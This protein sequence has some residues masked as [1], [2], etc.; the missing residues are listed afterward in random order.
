MSERKNISSH[1]HSSNRDGRTGTKPLCRFFLSGN[2]KFGKKCHFKHEKPIE[3]SPLKEKLDEQFFLLEIR[4]TNSSTRPTYP[5]S[6]P[7]VCFS[8]LN[9]E[10]PPSYSLKIIARLMQEAKIMANQEA[11]SVFALVS[12]LENED[13]IHTAIQ[14]PEISFSFAP[15]LVPGHVKKIEYAN[16]IDSKLKSLNVDEMNTA[17]DDIGQHS[18]KSQAERKF[19]N[20]NILAEN[21]ILRERLKS[22]LEVPKLM[23]V[24]QKL[25]AWSEQNYIMNEINHNQVVVISG[26][27]GC[28]KSTQV[29]QFILDDWLSDDNGDARNC[30]IVCTQPR[31]ISAIGVAE[32]VAAER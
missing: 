13:E 21:I 16:Q 31:R 4:F 25:P 14:G 15:E 9:P 32:R 24:R 30:S 10:F 6:T 29:P 11:P 8:T 5:R 27:T 2:C 22:R 17:T 18:N 23:K 19:L 3:G 20:K 28:G 12:L 1:K 26:M 7:L